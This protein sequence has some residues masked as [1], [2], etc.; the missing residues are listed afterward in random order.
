MPVSQHRKHSQ[1]G[2][3]TYFILTRAFV[4]RWAPMTDSDTPRVD[5]APSF[6][7]ILANMG[8]YA[9]EVLNSWSRDKALSH[10][11]R[12]QPL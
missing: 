8:L 12:R 6:L 10:I 7:S 1:A 2:S 9:Q 11:E 5:Y 4:L 3:S